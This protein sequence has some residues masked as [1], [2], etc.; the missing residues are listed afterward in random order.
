MQNFS[1]STVI[2]LSPE[3]PSFSVQT[4]GPV[5]QALIMFTTMVPPTRNGQEKSVCIFIQIKLASLVCYP[6]PLR[7]LFYIRVC[8]HGHYDVTVTLCFSD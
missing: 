1:L 3:Y 2:G 5:M 7:T 6:S 8:F 4:P